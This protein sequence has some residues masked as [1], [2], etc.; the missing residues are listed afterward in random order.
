MLATKKSGK[1]KDAGQVLSVFCAVLC[2]ACQNTKN[3]RIS[4]RYKT[5]PSYKWHIHHCVNFDHLKENG[6]KSQSRKEVL[7]VIIKAEKK[8]GKDVP[9][10][11]ISALKKWGFLIK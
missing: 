7:D 10:E 5:T 2:G 9:L 6:K 4:R 11:K 8:F 3:Y 1:D